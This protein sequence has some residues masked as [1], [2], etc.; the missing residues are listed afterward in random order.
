M[1]NLEGITRLAK[2]Y[3]NL[4]E[5][6]FVHKMDWSQEFRCCRD[7]IEGESISQELARESTAME[8]DLSKWKLKVDNARKEYRELNFFNTQQLMLLRR[9]IAKACHKSYFQVENPQVFTLLESVRPGL[10]TDHLMDAV[11]RAFKDTN[12]LEQAKDS[13]GILPSFSLSPSH[14][15]SQESLYRNNNYMPLTAGIAT[16]RQ[17]TPVK[18]PA[19]KGLT[20]IQ[21]FLNT[22]END[23]YSEQVALCALASLGVEAKED[24]LLLWCLDESDD[25][26]LESLYAEAIN[27]PVIAQE[28]A[29]DQENEFE[30]SRYASDYLQRFFTQYYSNYNLRNSEG[31][32]AL[33]KPRTNYLK[34]S[35]SS[36]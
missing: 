29:F 18:K 20:K 5:S 32:L 26:D 34:R 22:A 14:V 3:I 33:P 6:G 16:H 15:D 23:G 9:E 13:T 17:S 28:I 31:K 4:S 11:Q 35:F 12:L 25:A 8:A 7:Q 30:G 36:V 27:N 19:P 1:Q 24:D 21:C 10:Y 2:A